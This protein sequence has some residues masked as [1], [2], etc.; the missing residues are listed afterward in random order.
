[1]NAAAVVEA[2]GLPT[3][4]RVDLRVPKT[5]LV[6]N[7]APTPA[8]KRQ[9][10]D[11]IEELRWV[12]T[13][14]PTTVGIPAYSDAARDYAE[15]AVLTL[16]LR[17]DAKRSRLGEIVHRAIP[18]PVFLIVEHGPDLAV[19]LAHKRRSEGKADAV[20]LD[21]K[22]VDAPLSPTTATVEHC[23]SVLPLTHQPRTSLLALYQA[24]IDV[25]L[26]LHAAQRTG[27]FSPAASPAQAADRAAALE[28]CSRLEAAIATLRVAA[29]REKQVHRQV[30]LNLELRR[31]LDHLAAARTRL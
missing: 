25:L 21:G 30:Q 19:S 5:L 23:L 27:A 8:D 26:T 7:G 3:S 31:L 16:L 12:A 18:Y 28:E 10:Q 9:I 2:L 15:V 20:V 13:L 14:K 22:I 17:G 6:E 24:W 29:S 4:A 1:V 11:G